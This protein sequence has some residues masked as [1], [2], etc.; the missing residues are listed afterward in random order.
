MR[1][2]TRGQEEECTFM[3]FK[4]ETVIYGTSKVKHEA[5]KRTKI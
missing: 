1:K 3:Y 4:D 2:I 5:H